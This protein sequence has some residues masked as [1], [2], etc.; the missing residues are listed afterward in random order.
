MKDFGKD[1]AGKIASDKSATVALC[2]KINAQLVKGKPR[3]ILFLLPGLHDA[4]YHA[5]IID[6]YIKYV[7]FFLTTYV[8]ILF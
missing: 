3:Y 5:F 2:P 8:H 6:T 1:W 4:T 7:G